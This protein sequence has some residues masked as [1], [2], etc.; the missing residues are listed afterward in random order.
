MESNARTL[1]REGKLDMA[2]MVVINMNLQRV[3]GGTT[4]SPII[5]PTAHELHAVRFVSVI[6]S[7]SAD[8]D[9]LKL[10]ATGKGGQGS[11]YCR[12]AS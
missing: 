12:H 3:S 9:L 5:K 2:F 10:F 4:G 6:S 8:A 7:S 11:R 1:F